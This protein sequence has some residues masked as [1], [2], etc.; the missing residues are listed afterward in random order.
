MELPGSVTLPTTKPAAPTTTTTTTTD[1]AAAAAAATTTTTT[2]QAADGAATTQTTTTAKAKRPS[3]IDNIGARVEAAI[4]NG[5]KEPAKTEEVVV[6]K[7]VVV[8]DK[9]VTTT[10]EE[11]DDQLNAEIADKTKQMDAAG[12]KAFADL[13]YQM[14]EL[15]R[16]QKDTVPAAKIAEYETK[17]SDLQAK[18]DQASAVKP[19]DPAEVQTMKDRIAELEARDNAREEELTAVK[20]ERTD[21]FQNAV[22][23]PRAEIEA[24]VAKWA[25]KYE[26]TP[27]DFLNALN[28]TSDNQSDML[29][30]AASKLNKVEEMEFFGMVTKMRDIA[31]KEQT[32]RGQAKVALE[33]ITQQSSQQ[34]EQQKASQ[35]QA[36]EQA[37]TTNWAKLQ[38]ALP[39][40]LTPMTG[41]DAD[42]VAWNQAQ[43]DVE[44]FSRNVDLSAL[45]P[46]VQSE[47]IQR[48]AVHNLLV[49][50]MQSYKTQ[51]AEK[52]TELTAALAELEKFQKSVP[53]ARSTPRE[54]ATTTT[55]TTKDFVKGV[56]AK[57]KAAG[58]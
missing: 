22:T 7:P 43:K 12:R 32:F 28:D 49:A 10:G 33:K 6:D 51:L 11:T 20:V 8:E 35:R 27:A 38:E 53:S 48:G 55:P 41:D 31:E 16:A 4:K 30:D 45:K 44:T 54:G 17:V 2:Q 56:D 37:H 1:A 5:G 14:R 29:V 13:R 40:I 18:L 50:G 57:L 42:V 9:P 19:A 25:T 58:F 34:T 52:D 21:A 3:A 15:K 46:E 24:K 47:L 36:I 26:M 23:K 39:E